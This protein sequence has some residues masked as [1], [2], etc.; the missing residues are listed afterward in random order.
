MLSEEPP[1][2]YLSEPAAL[3]LAQY[4]E[5]LTDVLGPQGRAL[6]GD[7][8]SWRWWTFAGGAINQTL[9]HAALTSAPSGPIDPRRDAMNEG[10]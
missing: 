4:R 5:E 7:Q 10:Y 8:I 1:R 3:A 9:V 6:Q 2:G